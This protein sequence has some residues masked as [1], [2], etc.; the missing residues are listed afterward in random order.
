MIF[1]MCA[2]KVL[3][4]CSIDCSSPISAKISEKTPTWL[5]SRA[6]MNNPDWAITWTKPNVLSVMVLPPV[7]GPVTTIA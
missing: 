7:F 2:E 6:V 4:F 5:S 3:K 1:S